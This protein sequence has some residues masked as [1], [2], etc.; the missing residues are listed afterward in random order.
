MPD[1]LRVYQGDI[2]EVPIAPEGGSSYFTVDQGME[3][4]LKLVPELT[5]KPLVA[6][7]P[8]GATVGQLTVMIAG[9]T[10]SS[11]PIVTQVAVNQ[12]GWLHRKIDS[13]RM[14]L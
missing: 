13:I 11:V 14:R 6:P 1:E 12:G 7:L 2:D 4:K 9:K 3:R 10:A 5:D 8:K